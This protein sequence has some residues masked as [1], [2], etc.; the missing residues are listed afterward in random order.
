MYKP[1]GPGVL[2][3][4]FFTVVLLIL[5]GVKSVF[6][7]SLNGVTQDACL[8]GD[9]IH[10]EGT[11]EL[12]TEFGKGRYV[13]GFIDGEFDGYGRLEMPISWTDNEVYVGNWERGLRSGRG[14]HWNGK[15][16]LYIGQ[17]RDNKRNGTG[18]YFFDLPVWRENQH[19]E[20][21]LKE[22]T[23]N[24]TGEFVNDHFQG[25]GTYRWNK[26]HKYEGSFFAGKKHGFGTFYYAK[27]GTARHQLWNYG[28]FVR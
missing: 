19:S 10:G 4:Q 7:Q 1:S 12:T 17:W 8:R 3:S 2:A 15:G 22:N 9:C 5:L 26:G 25:K 13:G 16:D 21:W 14:T 20:Y 11:L 24:Y 27:T 6:G 28:D 18:S 23:E